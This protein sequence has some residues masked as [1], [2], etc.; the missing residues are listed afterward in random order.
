MSFTQERGANGHLAVSGGDPRRVGLRLVPPEL[1]ARRGHAPRFHSLASHEGSG[2][3]PN[4]SPGREM[5]ESWVSCFAGDAH[6]RAQRTLVFARLGALSAGN[7]RGDASPRVPTQTA[8]RFHPSRGPPSAQPGDRRSEGS[9]VR[10]CPAVTPTPRDA[11]LCG[12]LETPSGHFQGGD[13]RWHA[14]PVAPRDHVT[15]AGKT[16]IFQNRCKGAG[17]RPKQFAWNANETR[18]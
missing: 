6:A 3:S 15:G 18:P 17:C 5:K 8:P 1:R 14:A 7:D 12:Q 9:Q 2:E 13:R 10:A 11:Q 16:W 4:S